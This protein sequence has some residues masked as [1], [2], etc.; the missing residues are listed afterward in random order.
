M[1]GLRPIMLMEG[2]PLADPVALVQPAKPGADA[3]DLRDSL[4][5]IT[6]PEVLECL[7]QG[8]L[9]D[10]AVGV[11]GVAGEDELIVVAPGGEDAGH[12]FVGDDPVVHVVAE[13]V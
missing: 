5:L 7:G 9:F 8:L 12:V 4:E 6:L 1:S 3:F 13:S 2:V 10:G 11:S